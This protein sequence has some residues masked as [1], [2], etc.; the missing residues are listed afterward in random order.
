[1][2]AIGALMHSIPRQ[3]LESKNRVWSYDA[4]AAAFVRHPLCFPYRRFHD[5]QEEAMMEQENE[6]VLLCQ[7][8]K[9]I[10]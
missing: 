10:I 3:K 1:M 2:K 8:L 7:L 5:K 4:S 9:D 6:G